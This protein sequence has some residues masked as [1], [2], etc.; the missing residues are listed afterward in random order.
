VKSPLLFRQSTSLD[1]VKLTLKGLVE[2]LN[3]LDVLLNYLDVLLNYLDVLLALLSV[4][5]T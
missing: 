1:P 2:L 4:H 5:I 3:Y